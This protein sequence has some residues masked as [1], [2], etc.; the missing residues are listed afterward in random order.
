MCFHITSKILDFLNDFSNASSR[1]QQLDTKILQDATPISG[2]LRDLVS[3]A[4]PQIYGSIQLTIPFGTKGYSSKSDA[5]AFMK[6]AGW[7]HE[8]H[9]PNQVNAVTTLYMAF[10]AFMYL[11][12]GLG[13]LF[14]EPLL[15]SQAS[16]NY[17][18]PYAAPDLGAF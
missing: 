14:L 15:W 10:P 4:T 5:M 3:F 2:M 8:N 7:T 12:P 18:N 9:G 11:D 16:P 13:G 1:A 6:N 17:T